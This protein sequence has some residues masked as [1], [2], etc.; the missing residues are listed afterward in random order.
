MIQTTVFKAKTTHPI[1][2]MQYDLSGIPTKCNSKA[3]N[4]TSP[5]N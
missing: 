4:I 5:E 1:G 3:G 2:Q